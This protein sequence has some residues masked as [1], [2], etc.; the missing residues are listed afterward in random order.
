MLDVLGHVTPF[1]WPY[2]IGNVGLFEF[3]GHDL[4]PVEVLLLIGLIEPNSHC[5]AIEV[6]SCVYLLSLAYLLVL[7]SWLG[8]REFYSWPTI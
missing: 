3:P 1:V 8:G 5:L 2:H 4:G 7:L 6:G